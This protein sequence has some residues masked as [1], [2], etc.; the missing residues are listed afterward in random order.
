MLLEL[1]ERQLYIFSLIDKMENDKGRNMFLP[2]LA[3]LKKNIIGAFETITKAQIFKVRLDNDRVFYS[4]LNQISIR[5]DRLAQAIQRQTLP[6]IEV[7][8]NLSVKEL[9]DIVKELNSLTSSM[10]DTGKA[11]LVKNQ[12]NPQYERLLSA[13]RSLETK[14]AL[15]E[16]KSDKPMFE[17][18]IRSL[19]SIEKRLA[20]IKFE[21][22]KLEKQEI[23]IPEFPR[24]IDVRS[25]PKVIDAI[26][27][28]KE[29]MTKLPKSFPSMEFPR[30]IAV[31][32]FPPQKYPLPVTNININP[33]RGFAKSR[34]ITVTTTAT[35]LP[36][37]VLGY[38]RSIIVFNNSSSTVFLGGSD[39]TASNGLPILTQTYSPAL[40]AGPKLVIYGIVS[41]GTADVRTFEVSNENVGA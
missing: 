19:D 31:S 17:E 25:I 35:P 34:T 10:K 9:G 11:L 18:V 29:E 3:L 12:Q 16:G 15:L 33:L 32:N 24:E 22:P 20:N 38:R 23:K 1:V 26:K 4:Y 13:L 8:V 7:G 39:V 30:S 2:M 40:D 21:I 28:L 6:P 5:V 41:S 27:E 36:D 14:I 37:E